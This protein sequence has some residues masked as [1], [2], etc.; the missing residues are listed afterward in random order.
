MKQQNVVILG[1]GITGL[2]C[3]HYCLKQGILPVVIDTRAQPP[4]QDKLPDNV[5]L[6]AGEIPQSILNQADLIVASPG[7]ALASAALK[8]AAAAGVEII[9][10]IELFAR[11]VKA[12]VIAITGSNGKSTVTSLVGEM[13]LQAGVKVGVGGNIGVP[14]L[15][16]LEQDCDLYVLEL[17]S[18]QLETTHSLQPCIAT[19]LNVTEDHMDRYDSFD[20]Y[21]QAKLTIYQGAQQVLI[22]R[23]DPLTFPE[24]TSAQLVSFGTDAESDYGLRATER[25]LGL[26]HCGEVLLYADELALSGLHNIAN[27]LAALA[28]VDAA[29]VDRQAALRAAKTYTG[30]AHRCEFI[31]EVNG[32]RWINDSKATNVGATLAAIDGLAPVIQGKLHLIAGGDGKGGDFSPL[33]E[34]FEQQIASVVCFGQD[35]QQIASLNSK[36]AVVDDLAE[37]VAYCAK[38]AQPADWV[39]LSPACAS[40]DMFTNY[41]ARGDAFRA[42][43]EEL[44][45]H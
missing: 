36:C 42:L 13:A 2:S 14:A 16:L 40:L 25:G 37:A 3:V 4:G 24:K 34:A 27:V 5:T 33:K 18:F 31:K 17:S 11:A 39:L 38:V 41:M 20:A 6:H 22:N 30:L 10:D 19:V 8:E 28:L 26:T 35:K 32:V 23:D 45:C 1:L 9:G 29:G 43:V 44:P 12:P 15:S 7:I 21:R